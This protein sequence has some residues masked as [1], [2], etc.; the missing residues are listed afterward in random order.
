[1]VEVYRKP[2]EMLFFGE[3]ACVGA[4]LGGVLAML[5]TRPLDIN[6]PIL[7]LLTMWCAGIPNYDG[8]WEI[9]AYIESYLFEESDHET[10][11]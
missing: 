11:L 1:M 2:I 8:K 4:F 3:L 7:V 6:F 10:H 9:P 5:V